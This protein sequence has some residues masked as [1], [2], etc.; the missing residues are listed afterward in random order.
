[1]KTM[2]REILAIGPELGGAGDPAS[3]RWAQVRLAPVG[4]GGLGLGAIQGQAAQKQGFPG[5]GRVEA[6]QYCPAIPAEAAPG[7]AV[8]GPEHPSFGD[9]QKLGVE[10]ALGQRHRDQ[11]AVAAVGGKAGRSQ[12]GFEPVAPP[13]QAAP[14]HHLAAP[15]GAVEGHPLVAQVGGG[16][17]PGGSETA[18]KGP[19][20]RLIGIPG[21]LEARGPAVPEGEFRQSAEALQAEQGWRGVRGEPSRAAAPGGLHHGQQHEHGRDEQGGD[22]IPAWDHPGP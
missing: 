15:I 5:L 7:P 20:Q 13:F 4:Q 19:G 18:A 2:A 1:M 14:E 3:G 21:G 8:H 22:E 17:L 6:H 10:A 9:L 12:G 11:Q 16:G